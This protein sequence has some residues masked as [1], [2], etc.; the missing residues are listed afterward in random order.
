MEESGPYD[1][2]GE[3][4]LVDAEAGAVVGDVDGEVSEMIG[5]EHRNKSC[6]IDCVQRS[7]SSA[8]SITS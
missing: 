5:L 2:V 8:V 3:D 4:G 7:I 1:N 6:K